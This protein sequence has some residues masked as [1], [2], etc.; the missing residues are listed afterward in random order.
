MPNSRAKS[1][2]SN[3]PPSPIGDTQRCHPAI[4]L[5]IVHMRAPVARAPWP[6]TINRSIEEERR[7]QVLV[8]E[9][10]QRFC[11]G[12]PQAPATITSPAVRTGSAGWTTGFCQRRRSIQTR[13]PIRTR[14]SRSCSGWWVRC[15]TSRLFPR[16]RKRRSDFRAGNNTPS[17]SAPSIVNL[18]ATSMSQ[19]GHSLRY[20]M[21]ADR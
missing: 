2:F 1:L 12:D 8:R 7:V 19:M 14:R 6:R 3:V 10:W 9:A 17:L 18:S 11:G 13:H 21:S 15:R 16:C 4:G 5:R 20:A